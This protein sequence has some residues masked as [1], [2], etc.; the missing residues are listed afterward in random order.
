MCAF[1]VYGKQDPY[2]VAISD[3]DG[4]LLAKSGETV[5]VVMTVSSAQDKGGL[6]RHDFVIKGTLLSVIITNGIITNM[7]RDGKDLGIKPP[8]LMLDGNKEW[9]KLSSYYYEEALRLLSFTSFFGVE[10]TESR[11]FSVVGMETT[12]TQFKLFCETSA[13]ERLFGPSHRKGLTFIN[14]SMIDESFFGCH[15]KFNKEF[16]S[17]ISGDGFT[18][19]FFPNGGLKS[20]HLVDTKGMKELT[21]KE[22]DEK[23]NLIV[24]RDL[25][26]NPIPDPWAD[27]LL[28]VPRNSSENSKVETEDKP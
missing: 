7:V 17:S 14:E 24:V 1:M 19:D 12:E 23:G 9:I 21:L 4:L 3:A 20:L 10:S 6:L 2:Y 8:E 28:I 25:Q 16:L 18:A 11:E 13:R 5:S 27:G 22:W 15:V 26:K